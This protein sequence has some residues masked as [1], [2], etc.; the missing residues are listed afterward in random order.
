VP[1]GRLCL[2]AALALGILLGILA[3]A[4]CQPAGGSTRLTARDLRVTTE[5]MRARL[6]DSAFLRGRDATSEPIVISVQQV[7]NLTSDIIPPAE[8]WMLMAEIVHALPMNELRRHRSIS[9]VLPP[10]QRALARSGGFEGRFDD[11]A[12][13]GGLRPTHVMK[14]EFRSTTRVGR[15]DD[16]QIDER[17]DTYGLQYQIV[18]LASGVLVFDDIVEFQRRARGLLID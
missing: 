10:E 17:R 4:A 1:A 14:A 13:G 7:T 3:S 15:R 6:A 8:Q 2:R 16:G 9:F 18:D 11:E 12:D 5:E